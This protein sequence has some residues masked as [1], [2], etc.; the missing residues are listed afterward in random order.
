MLGWIRV[1][2]TVAYTHVA[3]V[4]KRTEICMIYIPQDVVSQRKTSQHILIQ[5]FVSGAA[6]VYFFPQLLYYVLS[7]PQWPLQSN[8]SLVRVFAI[9]DFSVHKVIARS[10]AVD[11]H[12][13]HYLATIQKPVRKCEWR[14]S[15]AHIISRGEFCYTDQ[16]LIVKQP[17]SRLVNDIYNEISTTQPPNKH[18]PESSETGVQV[19]SHGPSSSVSTQ[20]F[21]LF[22]AVDSDLG[23]TAGEVTLSSNNLV[24]VGTEL[25]ALG[26]PGIEVGLH[27]D[28]TG[29]ALVLADRP[30]LVEGLGAVNGGL[31]DA[32]GLGDLVR[33]AISS[34]GA[35]DS[36]VGRGVVGA[37]VLNDVVLDQR[38]AGPAVDG[39]VGV[40]LGA[41]GAGVGDGATIR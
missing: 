1:L 24:V 6:S 31:V 16:C 33:G 7:F 26:G 30:V 28:G 34:D 12:D 38:V 18:L 40:A 20:A 23:A 17:A 2:V 3:Q 36:G 5:L 37:E 14:C 13:A 29:A 8:L 32:L 39:E 41:V 22:S 19:C 35:L 11:T 15:K 25:H 10:I 9:N 21:R 27:V 4:V